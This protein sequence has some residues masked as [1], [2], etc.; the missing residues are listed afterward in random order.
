MPECLPFCAWR[1]NPKKVKMEEVVAPPYD[2]VSEKEIKEFK[3][4]SC[5]NIFHLELPESYKKA[6][7]LLENWIKSQILIKNKT[8]GVYFYELEF[9]YH[10]K[11]FMRKGFILLV[12]ISPFE[13]E[14]IFPHEKTYS[15]ITKDRFELLKATHFQFSQ[16][17]ALYEDPLLET[18]KIFDKK[19]E[20]LYKIEYSNEKHRLYKISEKT[21]IKKLLSFFKNKKFYI[22]DGHHRYMTALKFK[23]YMED[24]YGKNPLKDYNYVAMYVSPLEDKNL[25]MLPTYRIYYFND[26]REFIKK[27]SQLAEIVRTLEIKEEQNFNQF[28]KKLSQEWAILYK[29]KIIF[30]CLKDEVFGKIKEKEQILSEIP[31]Y[32]FLQILEDIFKIKEEVLRKKGKVKFVSDTRDLIIEAQKGAIGVI[33]PSIS[34]QI[35]KKVAQAKKL[36]PHKCTYFYPKNLTGLILN[37]VS[38]RDLNISF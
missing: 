23:E 11:I 6:K 1:Y 36:M 35:L 19:K 13:E 25:L 32:N 9:L 37:E 21:S 2:I 22:A 14:K 26:G 34:P 5:Y 15:N 20:L 24:F 28:F 7:E 30:F 33:F 4:K 16:I 27:I 38:G 31:L 29:R 17:F 8:P 3:N 18:L 10:N 12:K